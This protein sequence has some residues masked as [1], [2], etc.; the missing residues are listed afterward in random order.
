MASATITVTENALAQ[1]AVAAS[2]SSS[3]A[4]QIVTVRLRRRKPKKLLG[5]G[6]GIPDNE[7]MGRKSSKS[8]CDAVL[9]LLHGDETKCKLHR[10]A[11]AY[12]IHFCRRPPPTLIHALHRV[13]RLSQA[14]AVE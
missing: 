2:S 12:S 7:H 8:A 4:P 1:A 6:T 14:K 3:A 10:V 13:L 9:E 11:F 5:W